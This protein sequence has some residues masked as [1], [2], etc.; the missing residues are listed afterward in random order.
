MAI[1]DQVWDESGALFEAKTDQMC[2]LIYESLL[3]YK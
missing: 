1:F 2:A 3:G